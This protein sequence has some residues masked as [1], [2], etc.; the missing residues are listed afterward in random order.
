MADQIT[1][2]SLEQPPPIEEIAPPKPR[3]RRWPLYIFG[4]LALLVVMF[5]FFIFSVELLHYTES[6]AFCSSCHVMHPEN[7]AYVNSP[8]ARA[9]C[10]TCH[11]GPGAMAAFQAKLANMR[12]LWVYPTGTYERPIPSPIHSLRPV[13]VVCEQCHWPEI[14]FANRLVNLYRYAEDEQ[15]SLT[16]IALLLQTGGGTAEQGLG[17]G[18]H[19]HIENPVYY[20]ATDEQLQDI[21]WVQAEYNGVV[22]EYIATTST[23][24]QGDIDRAEKRKMD[25]VDCHNRASHDFRR[26]SDSIDEAM[27]AGLIA[28][29][30]P[31][32]KQQGVEVLERVYE[33]EEEAAQAIA[34]IADFYQTTLPDVYNT[35]RADVEQAVAQLQ[36]IFDRTAFPFMNV[37]W[38]SHRNNVGHRDFPGCFRCHDGQHLSKD[39]EA[40]RLQCNICH[41]IPQVALPGQP[42]PTVSAWPP[43]NEPESHLTTTWLS[44]HRFQFDSTCA[45]C[46][47]ISDPGG[48]SNTSFCSNSA[49]HGSEWVYVGLNAPRIREMSAPPREP[50]RGAPGPVPHPI[51]ATTNCAICHGSAGVLP[52]PAGHETFD[53]SLCTQCHQPLTTEAAPAPEAPGAEPAAT[54]TPVSEGPP[55]IPHPVAGQENCLLCHG[56]DAFKPYPPSHVGRP[57]TT[58]QT[59]HQAGAAEA[60]PAMPAATPAAGVTPQ[61]TAAPAAATASSIPH[62]IEGQENQCLAC[63]Y[64]GSIEPFPSNHEGF[65]NQM[66]LSCHSLED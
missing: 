36:N 64:T 50:G 62:A 23:L 46:H 35:R 60:T 6:A 8:H 7:T 14:F 52:Y 61:A 18:I 55:A 16:K 2:S 22:T 43:G 32:V 20:I 37:T 42:I 48:V 58:C 53:Q 47:T 25:C 49:C 66:C 38:Q 41:A 57:V 34:A 27:A 45:E 5:I 56:E 11:I 54:A 24:T 29:D 51:D 17:R 63:H 13:E 59:C 9:E 40:I 30:L 39:N 1:P 19:W 28:A 26:P 4:G 15:N 3:R 31:Y 65:T 21:P 33:T 10:G 12:Y 44:E